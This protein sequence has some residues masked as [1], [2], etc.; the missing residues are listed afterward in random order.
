MPTALPSTIDEVVVRLQ[1]IV[2]DCAARGD[3][4]GYF[5]ALYLR[6]TEAVRDGIRRGEFDDGPRM[7]RLDV[8]FAGR[9]LQAWEQYRSGELPTRSW[10]RAF[11]AA[12]S[13]D[14]MVLQ[15]LLVGINAHI[16]LD[17][18]IAAAR[19]AAG[20]ALAGLRGDF[21]RINDVLARLTPSVESQIDRMSPI[22]RTVSALAPRLDTRVVGFSMER[23]R[24]EA[25]AF[26]QK[27]APLRKLPQV[28]LMAR[29]DLE[30]ALIADAIVLHNPVSR[31]IQRE[32]SRD[33]AA[34]IRL[35][36]SGGY[37]VP[38]PQ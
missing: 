24:A 32:E 31:M 7:E 8:I 11:S 34:N 19:V 38:L 9:Y 5:A 17:L 22:L 14:L 36:A 6:M 16:N 27:L 23:A 20:P 12:A 30:V 4:N 33:I 21:D 15:A 3:R 37:T 2:A 28:D 26:A 10:Y 13:P 29:R 1:A 35:L 18:G 25:W